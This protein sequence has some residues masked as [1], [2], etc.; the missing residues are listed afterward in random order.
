MPFFQFGMA[1]KTD[2]VL[3]SE[4]EQEQLPEQEQEPEQ[5]LHDMCGFHFCATC[6]ATCTSDLCARLARGGVVA[7][8]ARY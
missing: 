2:G 8:C 4:Q 7:M 3:D 6:M 5:E 1:I